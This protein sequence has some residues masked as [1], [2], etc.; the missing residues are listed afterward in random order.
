MARVLALTLLLTGC[1]TSAPRDVVE[2]F[3]GAF[4]HL[5]AAELRPL[6]AEDGGRWVIVHLH[7]SNVRP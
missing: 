7:A 2:R 5:D 1:A 3:V 6:L 4:N